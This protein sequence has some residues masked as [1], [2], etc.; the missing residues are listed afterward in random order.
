[1]TASL[2]IKIPESFEK[3]I[4]VYRVARFDLVLT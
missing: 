2:L 3:S 1:M 4:I